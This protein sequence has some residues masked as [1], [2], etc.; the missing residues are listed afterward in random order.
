MKRTRDGL[1]LSKNKNTK[2]EAFRRD[3]CSQS[4]CLTKWLEAKYNDESED[5]VDDLVID[6]GD[7]IYNVANYALFH[8]ECH[9]IIFCGR[10]SEVVCDK[11]D[12]MMCQTCAKSNT[13]HDSDEDT[14]LCL[15][16][17]PNNTTTKTIVFTA[18]YIKG[19]TV[20]GRTYEFDGVES[21]ELINIEC[22]SP[23]GGLTEFIENSN[24]YAN[25]TGTRLVVVFANTYIQLTMLIGLMPKQKHELPLT[26]DTGNFTTIVD[27]V[28]I[29][30]AKLG[31]VGVKAKPWEHEISPSLCHA[32]KSPDIISKHISSDFTKFLKSTC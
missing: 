17:I 14:T 29:N 32:N 18:F 25:Y 7:T 24:S 4:T 15:E 13:V 16:C 1:S 5:E 8:C 6:C 10:A 22:T 3:I 21:K 27:I 9:S 19:D 23:H 28:D 30:R 12:K 26:P 20:S 31:I 2:I 11:C